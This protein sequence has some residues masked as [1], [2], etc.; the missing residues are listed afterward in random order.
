MAK[1]YWSEAIGNEPTPTVAEGVVEH[2]L[3]GQITVM[4][5]ETTTGLATTRP[6]DS[7]ITNSEL[8]PAA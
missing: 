6:F 5:E 4:S 1:R 8:P 2:T 3:E 7:V